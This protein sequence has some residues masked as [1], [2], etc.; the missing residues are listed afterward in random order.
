MLKSSMRIRATIKAIWRIAILTQAKFCALHC[1]RAR[2]N[3]MGSHA[4]QPLL[5]STRFSYTICMQH[6]R[7]QLF[8][9]QLSLTG[10][11][12]EVVWNNYG[13]KRYCRGLS[14][15]LICIKSD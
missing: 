13:S 10:S 14:H 4:G 15:E 12:R 7:Y 5:L 3:E 9:R 8:L 2:T 11:H 1:V 6:G